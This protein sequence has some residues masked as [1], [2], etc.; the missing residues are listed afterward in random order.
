MQQYSSWGFLV[1]IIWT[2]L[3]LFWLVAVGFVCIPKVSRCG[4][5]S[6]LASACLRVIWGEKMAAG[7]A[8]PSIS[9]D[10]SSLSLF[11]PP[12]TSPTVFLYGG[13]RR[14]CEC[15]INAFICRFLC[16]W[17]RDSKRTS[18]R[19]GRMESCFHECH[20]SVCFCSYIAW[21]SGKRLTFDSK[22]QQ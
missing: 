22:L 21:N 16:V 1:I 20:T 12:P 5:N 8:L 2:R 19:R 6:S 3:F 7:R 14:R 9:S 10:P 15:Y 11:I 4:W 17:H 18:S 13:G